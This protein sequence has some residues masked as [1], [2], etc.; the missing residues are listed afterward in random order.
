MEVS[1]ITSKC[2]LLSS[3]R[4]ESLYM[5]IKIKGLYS[6]MWVCVWVGQVPT[7]MIQFIL[8]FS[9]SH[10][11]LG[12]CYVCTFCAARVRTGHMYSLWSSLPIVW[13]ALCM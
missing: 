7:D 8:N 4:A 11:L 3:L 10:S 6:Y 12:M 1:S 9:S 2:G 13:S 5:Y